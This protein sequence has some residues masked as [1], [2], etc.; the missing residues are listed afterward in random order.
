[1]QAI[2]IED[3][4]EKEAFSHFKFLIEKY[5]EEFQKENS[6]IKPSSFPIRKNV[7]NKFYYSSNFQIRQET[8]ESVIYHCQETLKGSYT[9]Y[10]IIENLWNTD[11][12]SKEQRERIV[13][14]VLN[15]RNFIPEQGEQSQKQCEYTV[16]KN[17]FNINTLKNQ[18][19][20]TDEQIEY[21][22][23][24]KAYRLERQFDKKEIE[25]DLHFFNLMNEEFNFDLYKCKEVSR[26][27]NLDEMFVGHL[28]R[29]MIKESELREILPFNSF[30]NK[31]FFEK[32]Y[33]PLFEKIC[34]LKN[35]NL[36]EEIEKTE[37]GD[38][39]SLFLLVGNDEIYQCSYK[40][41]DYYGSE[42]MFLQTILNSILL[43]ITDCGD[44]GNLPKR[45]QLT[46]FATSLHDT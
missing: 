17:L 3:G 44:C 21:V 8:I 37:E 4:F 33:R 40:K 14:I 22:K 6:S 18:Y 15:H 7:L 20:F 45:K 29:A 26:S 42:W 9:F 32:Y 38:I 39:V 41:N 46:N 34:N 5:K 2:L 1:M 19:N 36:L 12:L 31:V 11:V 27:V 43:I 13:S 16:L 25:N 28:T 30:S 23:K 35:I 24:S 10:S